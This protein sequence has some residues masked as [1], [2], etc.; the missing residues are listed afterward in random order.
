MRILM[1]NYEYPPLGGG[2]GRI[3]MHISNEL[4]KL[5]H[6]VTV[7]TAWYKGLDEHENI[8]HKPEI[9]RVKSKRSKQ[10]QSNPL[11]MYDWMKKSWQFLQ[12]LPLNEK[13][14]ICFAN[15]TIP[16]GWL[17]LKIKKK[18]NIPYCIISHGHDIPWFFKKQMLVYHSLT[19]FLI[20]KI[21]KHADYL[22]VQ[23]Q[24]MK[25][26][27]EKFLGKKN[28]SKIVLIFNGITPRKI[29]LQKRKET[30]LTILFVGRF[31]KQ[32]SPSTFIKAMYRLSRMQIPYQAYMIGDGRM[33][34]KMEQLI[35]K[36]KLRHVKITGWLPDDE[37]WQYYERSH[38]MVMPSLIEGMSI[39]NIEALSAGLYLVATPVSGNK[40]LLACCDNGTLV[41]IKN[42]REVANAIQKFYFE[43][44]LPKQFKSER[45][46][47]KF[48]DLF[49][50]SNIAKQ[51]DVYLKNML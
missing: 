20:K 17:A 2:A 6:E 13:Y 24:Y 21:C 26:N 44:Y 15:F 50:W 40:E 30:P 29:N 47:D 4:Q 14:D 8:S 36:F 51:Y 41:T 43:Q 25:Q 16:G 39:S 5:G 45:V 3:S 38:V 27:A 32:K 49:L 18:F 9:I 34:K 28:S 22:F 10:Y 7:I 11:E 31:V 23:S 37:V 33:R 48:N 12:T 42:D 1:L 46:R 19:Y 35:G